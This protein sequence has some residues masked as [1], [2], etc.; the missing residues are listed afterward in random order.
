MTSLVNVKWLKTIMVM[1]VLALWVLATNHCRLELLPGLA[2]LTCCDHATAEPTGEHHE[3]DCEDDACAAVEEGLYKTESHQ[4]TAHKP[5]FVLLASFLPPPLERDTSAL[6]ARA[7]PTTVP[8][9]LPK[10][11]QFTFRTALP[12]R[13][14]SFVS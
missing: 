2:F 5:V 11:W 14:P 10:V 3:D 7:C 12:P 13:A 9:E 6:F 1:M 8:L 4:V